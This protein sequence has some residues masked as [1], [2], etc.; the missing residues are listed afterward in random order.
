MSTVDV[1]LPIYRPGEEFLHILELLKKQTRKPHRIIVMNTEEK[2][3]DNLVYGKKFDDDADSLRVYHLAKS[4]FDHAGT[5]NK[6]VKHSTADY[7]VLM[8]MD[9]VPADDKLI[10]HLIAPLERGEAVVSYARQLPKDDAGPIER[11]TRSFNYPPESL[12]KGAEDL[13]RLGIKTFFCSDVCA[14]YDRKTFD[15]LGGFEEPAIFNEDMIFAHKAVQAGRKI[16]YTADASVYH[17]HNYTAREQF[18]RNF[19]LGVSQADHPEI[20]EAYPSE[21]EG[22][23]MVKKTAAYLWKHKKGYLVGKLVVH[24]GAK[25]I[26]YRLGKRYK[27]LRYGTVRRCTSNPAYWNRRFR[28]F[29]A[30]HIDATK[31]YGRNPDKES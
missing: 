4:E 24:S 30:S 26:G 20:F 16:A 27:K 21:G 9:A 10:E 11:Y 31:G 12:L 7:F 1:I 18:R 23:R 5:R 13:K 2:Y 22:I 25:Y 29:A 8:T 28:K 6:G 19:D 17:S 15:A 14:A 3:F